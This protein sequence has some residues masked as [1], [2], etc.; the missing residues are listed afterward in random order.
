MSDD[1]LVEAVWRAMSDAPK[2]DWDGLARAAI[3][4]VRAHDATA[5]VVDAA[6]GVIVGTQSAYREGRADERRD[7]VAALRRW[8]TSTRA[9]EPAT[10][11]VL[12]HAAH[13]VEAG[14]HITSTT[15]ETGEGP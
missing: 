5:L 1:K 13:R 7:V 3:A 4:A 14:A 9:E 12:S 6:A 8:A 10:A 15:P 11:E 2:G